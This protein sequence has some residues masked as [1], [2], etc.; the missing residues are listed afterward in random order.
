MYNY[1]YNLM[2]SSVLMDNKR[3]N[4]IIT[5]GMEEEKTT[6]WAKERGPRFCDLVPVAGGSQ[7]AGF[8][9]PRVYSFAQLDK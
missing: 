3:N 7:E 2:L 1:M 8:T 5:Y 4:E 9:Q 6:G